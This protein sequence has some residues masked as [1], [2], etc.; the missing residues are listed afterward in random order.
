MADEKATYESSADAEAA[1]RDAWASLDAEGVTIDEPVASESEQ[2]DE[3]EGST[4]ESGESDAAEGESADEEYEEAPEEESPE[5]SNQDEQQDESV[6]T[7]SKTFWD[8]YQDEDARKKAFNETKEYAAKMSKLAKER[9]QRIKDLEAKLSTPAAPSVPEKKEPEPNQ[10]Q[11]LETTYKKLYETDSQVQ[12]Q[13]AGLGELK[14]QIDAGQQQLGAIDKELSELTAGI[15]EKNAQLKYLKRKLEA[16]PED[17]SVK[18]DKDELISEIMADRARH[19]EL[20]IERQEVSFAVNG[21]IQGYNQNIVQLRD[22]VRAHQEREEAQAVEAQELES[23]TEEIHQKWADA[24]SRWFTEN[25]IPEDEIDEVNAL[26]AR[27][28]AAE[29]DDVDENHL[30][31]WMRDHGGKLILAQRKRAEEKA[32]KQYATQKRKDASQPAPKGTI[33]KPKESSKPQTIDDLIA[34]S[35]KLFTNELQRAGGLR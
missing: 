5:E 20:R 18:S 19:N 33:K 7:E 13:V 17:L 1:A 14:T 31:E 28:A 2:Q 35:G 22:Y 11:K 9:E 27:I 25:N 21:Q 34:D 23:M 12:N 30:Y 32:I 10:A 4:P 16:D 15:S 3:D 24:S 29:S 6:S 26:M 8:Q